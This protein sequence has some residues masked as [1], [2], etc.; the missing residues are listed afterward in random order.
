MRDVR[1]IVTLA[2]HGLRWT[3]A[4]SGDLHWTKTR[5]RTAKSCGPGAATLASI[6]AAQWWRGNGDNK[7][8]SPGRARISRQTIARGKPGCLGCTCQTRVRSVYP[9]HTAMRAQSAPGFPC[10]LCG[11]EG[12]RDCRTQVKSRRENKS[13]CPPVIASEAKQSTCPR[14][15]RWI[16]S[17]LRYSQ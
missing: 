4:A 16:A 13:L 12:Q 14:G 6:H 8:R 10:A 2:W 5:Q 15:G 11:S 9:L 3:L 7:G 17:S 1:A